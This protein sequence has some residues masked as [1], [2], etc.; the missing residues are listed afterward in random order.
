MTFDV[1]GNV[2]GK[3]RTLKVGGAKSPEAA[4]AAFLKSFPNAEGVTAKPRERGKATESKL[5]DAVAT[6]QAEKAEK[7][8]KKL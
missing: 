2:N 7:E 1:T 5:A 6:A 3:P 4:V 8:A